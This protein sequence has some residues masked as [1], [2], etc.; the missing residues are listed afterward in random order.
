MSSLAFNGLLITG[1][2]VAGQVFI[3]RSVG[4][5]LR[6]SAQGLLT[7]VNGVGMLLGHK[8]VGWVRDAAGGEM[9]PVF[10]VGA[11]LT[12]VL[13]VLFLTTFRDPKEV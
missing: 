9:P 2:M 12:G 8:L 6:A 11:S 10:R 1:F 13:L 3:N 5:G 4:P 7:V